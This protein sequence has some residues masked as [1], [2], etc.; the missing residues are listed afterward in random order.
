MTVFLANIEV[1]TTISL[2][3][4]MKCFNVSMLLLAQSKLE[5]AGW[6]KTFS[7][8]DGFVLGLLISS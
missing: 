4:Y 5:L 6:L 2:A 3:F 8:V 7:H 1:V